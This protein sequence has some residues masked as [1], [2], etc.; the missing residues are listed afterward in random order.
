MDKIHYL[1]KPDKILNIDDL[2]PNVH[3]ITYLE[4]NLIGPLKIFLFP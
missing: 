2:P 1:H 4:N 3:T